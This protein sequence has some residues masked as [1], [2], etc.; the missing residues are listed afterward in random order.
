[1]TKGAKNS[2]TFLGLESCDVFA[3]QLQA[4]VVIIG[5]SDAMPYDPGQTSHASEAPRALRAALADYSGEW[6]RWDFDLDGPLLDTKVLRVLDGGDLPT[7]PTKPDENRALIRAAAK[8]CLDARAVP[9]LLGGDDSVP[10]PFFDAYETY[11]PITIV[12]IDAHIDWR[13]ELNGLRHTYTSTMRRASEMPWVERIVQVGMRGIGG[14]RR[15]DVEDARSWG[16]HIVPAGQVQERG[17]MSALDHVPEGSRCIVTLDCDGLDPTVVPAVIAPQP[18]GLS[19]EDVIRLLKG[20]S[21]R[22]RI[23]GFDLVELVPELDVRGLGVLT[24]AR[25]VCN[26]LGCMTRLRTS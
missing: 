18:G 23:V 22:A 14:A 8:Q 19:Y 5:A 17:I 9:F 20:L 13:D 25:I 12:Q 24:A 10:I 6:E 11:G 2:P 16:A 15:E 1:M 26:A 3:D 4:D 21:A 7:D